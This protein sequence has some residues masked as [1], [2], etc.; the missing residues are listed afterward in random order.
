MKKYIK[1]KCIINE[2]E[3][4]HFVC[5]SQTIANGPYGGVVYKDEFGYWSW[6]KV[7]GDKIRSDDYYWVTKTGTWYYSS[8]AK[9]AD[10]W[11]DEI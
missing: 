9:Q 6:D 2:M 11:D 5:M 7:T 1:P 4:N 10:L 8:Y 3:I